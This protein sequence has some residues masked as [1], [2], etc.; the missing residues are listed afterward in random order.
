KDEEMLTTSGAAEY[1]PNAQRSTPNI[2]SGIQIAAFAYWTFGH[3]RSTFSD[4]KLSSLN[5][6]AQ[7]SK[8]AG[9]NLSPGSW[10]R[11]FIIPRMATIPPIAPQS[12]AVVIISPTSALAPSLANY[13]PRN[14]SRSGNGSA[15][16]TISLSSNKA[17]ITVSSPAMSSNQPGGD[18]PNSSLG[19]VTRSSSPFPLCKI[20]N[21]KR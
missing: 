12:D 19:C 1:A 3:G 10:R 2:E 6:S 11:R 16:S 5:A 21:R 7:K 9:H 8:S 20:D 14:S 4:C 13:L 15:G 18:L 17:P